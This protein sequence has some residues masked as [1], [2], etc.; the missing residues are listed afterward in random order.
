[1]IVLLLVL[2][3]FAGLGSQP[4]VAAVWPVSEKAKLQESVDSAAY[5][6]TVLVA[7]GTYGRVVLRSGVHLLAEKGP[8][9]TLL[10]ENTFWV[11][12][13]EAVDSLASIEGF[14]IDGMKGAEGVVYS[15]ESSFTVKNCV[16]RSGWAGV[17]ALY[18]DLRLEGCTIRDCTNGIYLFE[19][20]GVLTGN[21]IQLCVVGIE[22]FSSKP[23]VVRNTITRNGLG[24][25][26]EKHS[27]AEIGGAVA[28]AN[29][30]WNNASGAV[31]NDSYQKQQ[32][33]R[34]WIPMTVKLPYNYWG[35]DCPDSTLFRGSV[36]WAP[37][38]DESGTRS[39]DKCTP[40]PAGKK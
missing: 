7:P 12:Q 27:D 23:R 6:D 33:V 35:S 40:K 20:G 9:Q 31:R 17:R 32:G 4:A 29:R 11:V 19:S 1:M 5:G 26:L 2:L 8:E 30:I 39:I 25:Q 38:V 24:I 14:S 28:S 21:D 34:T 13:A 10:K 37:W 3:A 16:I 36:E 18:S 22:I 15:Q